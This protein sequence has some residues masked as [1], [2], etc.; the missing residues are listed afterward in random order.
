V[1]TRHVSL[2]Q[3]MTLPETIP[4]L[5]SAEEAAGFTNVS[6]GRLKELADC[7][8]APCVR[9]DGGEPRFHKRD[10]I[11]WVKDNLYKIQHGRAMAGRLSISTQDPPPDTM[12]LPKCLRPLRDHLYDFGGITPSCVYFLIKESRVVYVGQSINLAARIGTHQQ[13]KDFDRVVY[14]WVPES[15]LDEVEGALIRALKPKLNGKTGTPSC[16]D[17]NEVLGRYGVAQGGV[18]AIATIN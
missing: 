5:F 3:A 16:G 6:A 18:G 10:I 8:F 17:I 11:A 13:E 1:N 15:E 7:G 9:I 12:S 14:M 4:R 2:K